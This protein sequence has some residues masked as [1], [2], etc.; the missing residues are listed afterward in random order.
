VAD[1]RYIRKPGDDVL[2]TS[3]TK[4]RMKVVGDGWQERPAIALKGKSESVA[5]YAPMPESVLA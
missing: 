5:L 3:E 4:R 1:Q 2:I